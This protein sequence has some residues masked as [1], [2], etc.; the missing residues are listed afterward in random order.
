MYNPCLRPVIA[1]LTTQQQIALT[2][3]NVDDSYIVTDG[4]HKNEIGTWIGKEWVW[5]K[6]KD[7]ESVVVTTSANAGKW[8]YDESGDAWTQIPFNVHLNWDTVD[9]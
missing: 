4:Y 5:Y 2:A 9:W 7:Q 1:L 6:P 8:I 3:R